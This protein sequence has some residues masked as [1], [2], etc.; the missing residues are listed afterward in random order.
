MTKTRK[1]I[2]GWSRSTLLTSVAASI[3]LTTAPQMAQAQG[4]PPAASTIAGSVCGVTAGTTTAFGNDGIRWEHNDSGGTS[5]DASVRNTDLFASATP[6]VPTN[7]TAQ[8]N[9]FDYNWSGCHL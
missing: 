2:L 7:I 1:R 8:I 6:A 5:P 4:V 3:S 9:G